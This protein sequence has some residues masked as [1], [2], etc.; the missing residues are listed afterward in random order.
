M[1]YS[2]RPFH[3]DPLDSVVLLHLRVNGIHLSSLF[4]VFIHRRSLLNLLPPHPF[5][6]ADVDKPIPWAE[7]APPIAFCIDLGGSIPSRWITTTCGSRFVVLPGTTEDEDSDEPDDDFRR[8]PSAIVI[9]DF[10]PNNV[11]KAEQELKENGG[12]TNIKKVVSREKRVMDAQETFAEEIVSY[13]PYV[14]SATEEK[15]RLDGVLM[16]EDNVL[17]LQTDVHGHIK[18]VEIFHFG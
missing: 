11:R 3:Y 13:L 15:Y 14:V 17:G 1:K 16:D 7:W 5:D 4:T 9:F 12:V 8:K 6:N 18:I 2:D 10:N